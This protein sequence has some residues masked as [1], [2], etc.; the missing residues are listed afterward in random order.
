MAAAGTRARYHTRPS[1]APRT[2]MST[3]IELAPL[4][5]F[6]LAY[7]FAGGI[8]VATAVLM[9]GM[10]LVLAWDWIKT[11]TVTKMHLVSAILVWVLGA[12]TLILRD[13]RF[14]QWK[15]TVFVWLVAAAV[16]GSAFIGKT[17]LL[18]QLLGKGLPEDHKVSPQK[19]RRVT[20]AT[21][22][23]Y[24]VLG[25]VNLAVAFGMSEAAWVVFKS[26]IFIPALA[27]FM[28]VVVLWLLHG[29]SPSD[30]APPPTS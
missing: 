12:A 10:V 30:E 22:A 13:V 14:L 26:W 16:L 3:L 24:L 25:A 18:E 27:V 29:Y 23:F 7:K 28:F 2:S 21:A 11:R 6:F 9:G 19:W 17:T 15:A 8:Y 1:S 4:I 20:Y 5:A